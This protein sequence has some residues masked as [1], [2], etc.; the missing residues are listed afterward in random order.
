MRKFADEVPPVHPTLRHPLTHQ[1][2]RAIGRTRKGWI[3][4]QM[5]GSQPLGGPA[6]GASQQQGGQQGGQ[7]PGQ[8]VIPVLGGQ[9]VPVPGQVPPGMPGVPALFGGQQMAQP[10]Q[11][12]GQP[13]QQPQQPMYGQQGVMPLPYVLAGQQQFNP[14]GPVVPGQPLFG[15]QPG[16]PGQQ[17]GGQQNAGGQQGGGQP[18][19]G[20]QSGGDGNDGTWDKPYPQK[21]VS[22]MTTDEQNAYFKYH[23]RKL[24]GRLRQY[25]DY[26]Q[27]KAQLAQLQQLTQT[28]WQRAVLEAEGR[29]QQKAMET[30]A[31]QMVAVAFQGAARNR[32]TPDQIQA[33]L[34][35]LDP[36][37][38]VHNG[39]VD[40]AAVDAYVDTVAPAR[41]G[42][43]PLGQQTQPGQLPVQQ[44]PIGQQMPGQQGG[45]LMPGQYLTPGQPGYGQQP[46]FGPVQGQQA[47][48][49]AP[50]PG[51][52]NVYAPQQ[53]QQPGYGQQGGY[54][55]QQQGQQ[56]AYAQPGYGQVPIP[57]VPQG[58]GQPAYPAPATPVVTGAGLHG[59]PGLQPV[60]DFGQG[61]GAP[62]P[63]GAF[64][65][66]AQVAAQRHGKTRS[67]QL[68]ESNGGK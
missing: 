15:Q 38:F 48:A 34:N 33:Q 26:D 68:A 31:A 9:P 1:P 12:F 17:Q 30:A 64:A 39:M 55:P 32:M 47:G 63:Q 18:Q 11:Q 5:G 14:G 53:G 37:R 16:Q 51:Q 52:P 23:N 49:Y 28:E 67:Q 50:V 59:L 41:P 7:Q 57:G 45:Y 54:A 6:T 40:V 8:P 13:G 10:G 20:G 35:V 25:G 21:P 46:T 22:E 61:T 58:Y 19:G 43:V 2:I 62:N 56:P 27:I 66:G 42:M 65:A 24:E 4:P 44:V 3:W 29:G 60:T 36:R